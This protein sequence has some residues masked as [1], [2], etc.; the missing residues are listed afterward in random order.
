MPDR[1]ARINNRDMQFIV[2]TAAKSRQRRVQN[3]D[4]CIEWNQDSL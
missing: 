3:A 1:F 2:M 4:R